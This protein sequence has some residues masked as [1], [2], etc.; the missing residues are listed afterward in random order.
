MNRAIL[1]GILIGWLRNRC[2]CLHYSYQYR[3]IATLPFKL[4]I[5][6]LVFVFRLFLRFIFMF[7]KGAFICW[8]PL[9]FN[10]R[11]F[12]RF[13]I[14]FYLLSCWEDIGILF[15]DE[16]TFI[17]WFP[18]KFCIFWLVYILRLFLHLYLKGLIQIITSLG[19]KLFLYSV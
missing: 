4:C 6:L 7:D 14:L 13:N 15:R 17:W 5:F 3:W 9:K 2:K 11:F 19:W 1:S 18:L 10:L 12:V 16:L 8:L